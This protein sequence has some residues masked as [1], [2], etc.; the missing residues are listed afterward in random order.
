MPP[1]LTD[2]IESFIASIFSSKEM[3]NAKSTWKSQVFATK[4][5]LSELESIKALNC[6]SLSADLP[7]FL[8]IPKAVN[9][10]FCK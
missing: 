5:T 6:G 3:P 4:H 10:A 9:L 1:D 8:V 2:L 7:A